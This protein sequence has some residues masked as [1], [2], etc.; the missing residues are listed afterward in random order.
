[1]GSVIFWFIKILKMIFGSSPYDLEG[2]A[3]NSSLRYGGIHVSYWIVPDQISDELLGLG[4]KELYSYLQKRLV[5]VSDQKKYGL[6]D[7]WVWPEAY[8]KNNFEG[9]CE[10]SSIWLAS[11]LQKN[12]IPYRMVLGCHGSYQ[13][14]KRLKNRINHAW[15]MVQVKDKWIILET[16]SRTA[17]PIKAGFTFKYV[18]RY[19]FTADQVWR[20]E[21]S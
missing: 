19:S 2:K 8:E 9:D 6:K 7:F 14:R 4:Y 1:M 5:Y 12:N 3:Y 18:P 21:N 10:D 16:T 20:H 15:V 13:E 17:K 11:A